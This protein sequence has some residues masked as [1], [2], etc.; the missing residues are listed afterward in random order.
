MVGGGRFVGVVALVVM[1]E[2]KDYLWRG[3]DVWR[4]AVMALGGEIKRCYFILLTV[5]TVDKYLVPGTSTG[6]RYL[7]IYT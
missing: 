4:S 7:D 5:F 1:V 2:S 6:T 3:V